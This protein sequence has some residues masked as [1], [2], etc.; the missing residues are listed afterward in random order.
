MERVGLIAGSGLG[1][2]L[3]VGLGIIL[4]ATL[5]I[6]RPLRTLE[7]ATREV[8]ERAFSQPIPVRGTDEIAQLTRA[9]N[10]MAARLRELD[11]V[12]DEFFSAIS[13]DL[14]TPLSAIQWSAELLQRGRSGALP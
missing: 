7:A 12:K 14:R 1:V 10:Q 5:R 9:F 2:S 11:A 3:L 4:F 8:A 6:A 13:H